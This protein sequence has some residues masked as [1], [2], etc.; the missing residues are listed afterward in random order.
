MKEPSTQTLRTELELLTA[1]IDK[2]KA[3]VKKLS[4]Q[5]L[6]VEMQAGDLGRIGPL[7]R[8]ISEAEGDNVECA[9]ETKGFH[10]NAHLFR[11]KSALLS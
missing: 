4:T 7:L 8:A 10:R 9:A 6:R 5:N 3:L 11:E 2:A 1:E